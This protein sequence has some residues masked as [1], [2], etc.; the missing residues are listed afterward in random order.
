M[1]GMEK[2]V[3]KLLDVIEAHPCPLTPATMA[4]LQGSLMTDLDIYDLA[5]A[6][7]QFLN[8][9]LVGDVFKALDA[10][11][12]A[13][14]LE[15]WRKITRQFTEKSPERRQALLGSFTSVHPAKTLEEI[16]GKV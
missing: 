15:V 10:T 14:G 2:E 8:A 1:L 3:S 11:E 4:D 5:S 13:N 12:H 7:W 9:I 6:M 16:P